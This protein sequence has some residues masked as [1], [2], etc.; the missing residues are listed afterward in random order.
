MWLPISLNVYAT[1]PTKCT[2]DEIRN[3]H[4][5]LKVLDYSCESE[6]VCGVAISAPAQLEDIPFIRFGAVQNARD[7][8]DFDLAFD[9]KDHLMGSDVVAYIYGT[10]KSINGI[11]I[12][13]SYQTAG[14]G[15]RSQFAINLKEHS[16]TE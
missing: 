4:N 9:L 10:R 7:D 3:G 12:Y 13:A 6:E 8:K 14:V 5:I 15:C 1:L 16:P 2:G 11:S